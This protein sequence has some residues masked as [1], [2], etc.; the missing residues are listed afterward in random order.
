MLGM[1]E[2]ELD[3]PAHVLYLIALV[4][5]VPGYIPAL[6]GLDILDSE[7]FYG[8]NVTNGLVHQCIKSSKE[9]TLEFK[10]VWHAPL[11]RHHDIFMKI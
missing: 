11:T 1:I 9:A 4:N 5:I 7:Q 2:V 8:V 3:T 10:D 6:L